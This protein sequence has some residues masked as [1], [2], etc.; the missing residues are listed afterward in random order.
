MQPFGPATEAVDAGMRAQFAAAAKARANGMPRVGWKIAFADKAAQDR[1]GI[2]SPLVGTL[3]GPALDLAAPYRPPANGRPRIEAE[4]ALHLGRDVAPGASLEDA[5]AAIDAVSPAIEFV[6]VSKMSRDLA[7][8][9]E[10]S[11]L[12]DGVAFGP[13]FPL[14]DARHLGGEFPQLLKAGAVIASPLP[15]RVPED[16]APL[17]AMVAAVVERYGERLLAGDRIICGSYIEPADLAPGDEFVVDFGPL[18]QI[19]VRV[20]EPREA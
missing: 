14:A 3:A 5:S 17:V 12:H 1:L 2:S 19:P 7:V 13:T 6:D 8:M 18:G 16:L 20:G 9:A 10:G 4:I 11:I 15:G